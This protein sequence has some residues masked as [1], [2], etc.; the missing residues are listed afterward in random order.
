MNVL[1]VSFEVRPRETLTWLT[2]ERPTRHIGRD[3]SN[4][5][6]LPF[7]DG[8]FARVVCS[9]GLQLLPNRGQALGEMH[10]VLARD[11]EIEVA[12]RAAIE[13]NPPFA[14]L[15]DWLERHEGPR[16]AAAVR[17]HYCM[18]EPDDLRGVLAAAAFDDIRI[19][20]ARRTYRCH[21]MEEL[22]SRSGFDPGI[23]GHAELE[24]ALGPC[25]QRD[26]VVIT[27]ET[28]IG[29]ARRV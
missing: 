3:R 5:I 19:G 29:R 25:V 13:R 18:P 9:R 6:D 8:S 14:E 23:V 26:G 16:R 11:G 28:V 10:R 15:A 24:R 20:L 2:F 7:D 1:E 12:V 17:W 4:G 27:T 21:S 22:L